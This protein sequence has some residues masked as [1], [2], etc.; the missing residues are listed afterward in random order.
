[1]CVK[2]MVTARDEVTAILGGDLNIRDSEISSLNNNE[3][4][5]ASIIDVWEHLGRR[6]DVQYTWDTLRNT[7]VQIGGKFKPRMRF[8]RVLLR[9]GKED[10]VTA[11]SFNLIGIQKVPGTQLFASDHWGILVQFDLKN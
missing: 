8:D 11:K 5:P 9:K 4:L 3:G 10:L 1:M 7:N 2:E 6:K